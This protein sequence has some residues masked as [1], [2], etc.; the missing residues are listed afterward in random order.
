ML[1]LDNAATTRPCP[2]A[3]RILSDENLFFNPSSQHAAGKA[4]RDS[5]ED[6]RRA[7][8][9]AIGADADEIYFTSCGT[10]SNALALLGAAATFREP[11]S[12]VTTGL[13]HPSVRENI[14]L[15]RQRGWGVTVVP[16]DKNGRVSAADVAAAVTPS[17]KI[18]S[19]MTV[20]HENGAVL[21]IAEIVSR[22]RE[23]ARAVVHTDAVQGFMK[24]DCGVR[25]TDV[26]LLTLS[27]HKLGGVRGAAA[28]YIRRGLKIKGLWLG[29]GQERGLRSGTEAAALIAALA[30][31]VKC[32]RPPDGGLLPYAAEKLQA[33]GAVIIPPH[34]APHILAFALAGCPGPVVQRMLSDAG[35]CVSTGAA[36]SKGRGSPV[37][38]AMKLPKPVV[39]GALRISFG[40]DNTRADIDALATELY[41]IKRRFSSGAGAP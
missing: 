31:A 36:C 39:D 32:C 17:T 41:A 8:A 23:K 24:V 22:I 29:G 37:L 20:C 33:L 6:S 18:V 26:D 15:L 9:N 12:I 28:I 16:P 30:E 25:K 19:C 1:Y 38:T 4:A 5:L 34:D 14:N 40:R 13:E 2:E 21:P 27:A 10:E 7:V 3:L 11:Q 35:I